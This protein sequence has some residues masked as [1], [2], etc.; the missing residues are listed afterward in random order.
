M[1]AW[2]GGKGSGRR[3]SANDKKFVEGWD[4]IFGSKKKDPQSDTTQHT[5]GVRRREKT[6]ITK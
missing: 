2:H 5:G 1:S 4:R 6:D 3:D